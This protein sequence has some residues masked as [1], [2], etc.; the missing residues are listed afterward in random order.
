MTALPDAW[1]APD[2]AWMDDVAASVK[3]R[4]AA[5]PP[6]P[7]APPQTFYPSLPEFVADQLAPMYRRPLGTLI[8]CPMWWK[9][10]EAIAR[11]EALWRSW[12]HLRLEPALGMSVWFRDHADVH[13]PVLLDSNGPFHGC[14][15]ERGHSPRLAALPV[16]APPER[17]FPLARP[18]EQG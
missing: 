2:D 7:E 11:L 4:P 8:W 14:N 13:M 18:T 5:P 9:H 15:E 16:E 1:G 6:P 3:P 17:L 10:A 12:E